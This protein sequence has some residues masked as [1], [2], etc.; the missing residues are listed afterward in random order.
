[1]IILCDQGNST[2][3]K[4]AQM[5]YLLLD[6]RRLV[7]FGRFVIDGSEATLLFEIATNIEMTTFL[8]SSS[9]TIKI[10]GCEPEME[11]TL[12][13]A[14]NMQAK[15]IIM[16][17]SFFFFFGTNLLITGKYSSGSPVVDFNA[18]SMSIKNFSLL[19]FFLLV[20]RGRPA[21]ATETTFI[22]EEFDDW[23]LPYVIG[24]YYKSRGMTSKEV[25]RRYLMENHFT[26]FYIFFENILLERI[27]ED[28]ADGVEDDITY[29]L[30]KL[31]KM[32]RIMT[33]LL[34]FRTSCFSP[35]VDEHV[36]NVFC[37]K[38]L[39]T[40]IM[41]FFY[42]DTGIHQWTMLFS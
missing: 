22:C 2:P 32:D 9:S 29:S 35:G 41:S 26:P 36:F 39:P 12:K 25:T 21:V 10:S 4:K 24:Q 40:M 37:I 23:T 7:S 8:P 30:L 15:C 17:G 3:R 27:V 31:V 20:S 28:K 16:A 11:Q 38:S 19:V 6:N 1:M 13:D 42:N 18:L 34:G 5:L 14:P 33:L